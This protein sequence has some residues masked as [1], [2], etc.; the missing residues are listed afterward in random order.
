MGIFSKIF[1]MRKSYSPEN[2]S[3]IIEIAELISEND[4][5][6]VKNLTQ[7]IDDPFIYSEGMKNRFLERGI[8]VSQKETIDVDNICWI[9]LIEELSDNGFLSEIDY[10]CDLDEFLFAIKKLKKYPI[11]ADSVQMINM[12]QSDDAET[13]IK[14]INVDLN[15]KAFIGMIDIDS[16]SYEIIIVTSDVYEK[17]S[18]IARMNGHKIL[19]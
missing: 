16:D 9:A 15:G 4:C 13:W 6:V 3:Y 12:H 18:N 10:K 5:N 11:I 7:C 2:F 17:I 1:K 8:C 14:A 19:P